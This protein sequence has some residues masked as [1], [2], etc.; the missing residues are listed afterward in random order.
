MDDLFDNLE[1]EPEVE[2]RT[3]ST[4]RGPAKNVKRIKHQRSR[5]RSKEPVRKA[6]PPT[7]SRK[8]R[9][10]SRSKEQVRKA[11]AP[12]RTRQRGHSS[13]RWKRKSRN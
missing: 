9:S 1:D 5:S 4:R 2:E 7:S 8:Q 3:S 6:P 11:P 12:S 13:P 10:R